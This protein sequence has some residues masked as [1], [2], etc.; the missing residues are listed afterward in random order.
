MFAFF[1]CY[2]CNGFIYKIGA[3]IVQCGQDVKLFLWLK[4]NG[5][6][7]NFLRYVNVNVNGNFYSVFANFYGD[8]G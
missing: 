2:Y 5:T 3:R 7:K 1:V 4:F 6:N 8:K